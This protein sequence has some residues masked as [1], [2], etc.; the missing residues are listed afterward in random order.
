[1]VVAF[2]L[3][4]PSCKAAWNH[5]AAIV[6]SWNTCKRRGEKKQKVSESSEGVEKGADRTPAFPSS[7]SPFVSWGS[8]LKE[9][10]AVLRAGDAVCQQFPR[11]LVPLGRSTT[12]CPHWDNPSSPSRET[13]ELLFLG[14]VH[15]LILAKTA[16]EKSLALHSDS[17]TSFLA[18]NRIFFSF[19]DWYDY[20]WNTV[21]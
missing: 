7:R 11:S 12:D 1:M 19:L 5:W 8:C 6:S 15:N 9:S 13:T 20:R 3:I 21:I 16:T 4:P 10:Q 18:A 17:W 14:N 2:S